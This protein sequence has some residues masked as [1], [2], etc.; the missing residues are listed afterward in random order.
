M[1]LLMPLGANAQE[2]AVD[3]N[4]QG[5]LSYYDNFFL[6][7]KPTVGSLFVFALNPSF[8]L[9]RNSEDSSL[10][11][12][13]SSTTFEVPAEPPENH[14]NFQSSIEQSYHDELNNWGLIAAYSRDLTIDTEFLTTG[15]LLPATRRDVYTLQP[16]AARNLTE[17]TQVSAA[18]SLT[19]TRYVGVTGVSQVSNFHYY[20][21]PLTLS[22]T[23]T[24]ADSISLTLDPTYYH[25]DEVV[26]NTVSEQAQLGWRHLMSERTSFNVAVGAFETRT[27]LAETFYACPVPAL[28]CYLGFVPFQEITV[29]PRLR[30]HGYLLNSEFDHEW[31]ERDTLSLALSRTLNPSGL[32]TLVIVD[33]FVGRLSEA[34]GPETTATLDYERSRSS[35]L[36]DLLNS[37][38]GNQSFGVLLNW[39]PSLREN[40]Q[41]G[42]RRQNTTGSPSGL[43]VTA[44]EAFVSYSY[45]WLSPPSSAPH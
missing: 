42:F 5:T 39:Q 2:L 8:A 30:D 43:G 6:Q 21:L 25:N 34:I 24:P 9:V 32:G 16:T 23:P 20:A 3:A 1:A 44:N 35:Y 36:G 14:T 40:V 38:G 15:V 31:S 7:A 28:F 10:R 37:P 12:N 27:S 11:A 26:D 13:F 41:I 33:T 18:L 19:D 29:T 22:H 45:H 17:L 4:V